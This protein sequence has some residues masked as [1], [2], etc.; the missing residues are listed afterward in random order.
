MCSTEAARSLSPA[1]SALALAD[2][3]TELGG[4]AAYWD[5]TRA[6]WPDHPH[7]EDAAGLALRFPGVAAGDTV[8]HTD[9]RDDTV[10]LADDGRVLLGDWIWPA[11][12]AAWLDSVWAMVGPR[13][14]G[15]D[16]DAALAAHPLTADVPGEDVDVAIALLLGYLLKAAD[17][18]VPPSSPYLREAQRW[19]AE[20]CWEWLGARRGWS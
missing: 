5:H 6:A 17:D 8:V 10:L 12:G 2:V 9:V 16:V 11:R 1:P 7:V 15:L 19:Q 14:D 3:G 18:P 13:G 4:W 20:V